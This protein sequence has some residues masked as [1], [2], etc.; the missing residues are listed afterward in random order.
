MVDFNLEEKQW[1]HPICYT[2]S[3]LKLRKYHVAE[4]VGKQLI[5]LITLII[6]LILRNLT[7]HL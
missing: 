1:S 5:I 3:T 2:K 7:S 4:L 6:H